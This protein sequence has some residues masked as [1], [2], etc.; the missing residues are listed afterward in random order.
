[1]IACLRLQLTQKDGGDCEHDGSDRGGADDVGG[2]DDEVWV[3]GDG[4]ERGCADGV[5]SDQQCLRSHALLEPRPASATNT[6][7]I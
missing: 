4:G 2:D 1:M 6:Q 5:A 7:Y 3:D